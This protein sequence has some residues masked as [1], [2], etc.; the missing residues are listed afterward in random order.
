MTYPKAA[1]KIIKIA[2]ALLS[3][4]MYLQSMLNKSG[5]VKYNILWARYYSLEIEIRNCLHVYTLY[6]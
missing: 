4:C 1:N 5:C 2:A 6:L 3:S